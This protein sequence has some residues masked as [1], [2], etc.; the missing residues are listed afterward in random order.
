[1]KNFFQISFLVLLTSLFFSCKKEIKS[2]EKQF[3]ELQMTKW[4]LGRWENNS[5]EGNLSE[6]WKKVNDSTFMGE[7]YFVIETDTVFAEHIRLEERNNQL[8]YTVVIPNQN[9]GN[10]VSFTLIKN[11]EK[12]LIF[13]NSK[14]DFPNQIWYNKVGSDSLIAQIRGKKEGKNTSQIFKMKKTH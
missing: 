9:N 2:Q 7:S 10:P 4:L 8:Y 12:Q 3:T 14:H 5:T 11:S 1:M 6:S 13:E